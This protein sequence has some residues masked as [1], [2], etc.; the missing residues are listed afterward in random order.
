MWFL[1]VLELLTDHEAAETLRDEKTAYS[2]HA[3][4]EQ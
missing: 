1:V 2:Y 3:E 4:P